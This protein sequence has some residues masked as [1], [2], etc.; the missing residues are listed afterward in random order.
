MA[1]RLNDNDLYVFDEDQVSS[2]NPKT[3]SGGAMDRFMA[4]VTSRYFVLGVLFC[5]FG[6][7]ILIKTISLQFSDYSKTISA[8]SVGVSHQYVVPAPRGDIVDR[9]GRVIATSQE[10]NVLMLANSGLEN[11]ELNAICLEL[12][13]LFDEYNCVPV[14]DLDDYFSIDPYEF[15]KSDE[16]IA[17]W[18]TNRNLFD[19]KEPN[20]NTVVTY[21]DTNV[22][23]DPQIFFL[24]LRWLFG[25]DENYT[26]DE[27]YRIVRIRYQIYAD[28]WS[29]QTGTPVL[30]ARDVPEEL[31]RILT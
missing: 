12:S 9:N 24:Y 8:T 13:Y 17:L 30:I 31:I 16:E 19:L 20:I 6:V 28:N 14:A 5:V 15:L 23:S 3:N 29:F 4:F 1:K 2:S 18:Q 25:I 7:L 10:I 26:E 27:A 22:K 21:T 11:T